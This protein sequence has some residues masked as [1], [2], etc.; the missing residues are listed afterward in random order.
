MPVIIQHNRTFL[1]LFGLAVN[2]NFRYP[3]Y[4]TITPTGPDPAVSSTIGFF[5]VGETAVGRSSATAKP[6]S[7]RR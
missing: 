5:E 3:K 4:F 7:L 1:S 6:V 2:G